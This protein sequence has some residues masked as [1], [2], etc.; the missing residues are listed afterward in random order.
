MSEEKV[1]T[2]DNVMSDQESLRRLL[3][4][5]NKRTFYARITGIAAVIICLV[6]VVA[7][8]IL[9]PK[10]AA[11]LTEAE[12]TIVKAEESLGNI[13]K[14]SSELI[15]TSANMNKVLEDNAQGLSDALAEINKIDIETLNKA[16]S[17]LHDTVEP[18]AKFFNAFKR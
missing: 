10:A 11:V 1:I 6:F 9:I 18:M 12:T 7:G 17:D 15:N 2:V 8:C 3:E 16:I 13:D 14:L 4:S 5:N